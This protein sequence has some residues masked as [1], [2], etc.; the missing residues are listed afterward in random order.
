MFSRVD[1]N[2]LQHQKLV[3]LLLKFPIFELK[4]TVIEIMIQI[5]TSFTANTGPQ[6]S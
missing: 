5:L 1:Q 4:N 3:F 6:A 2:K